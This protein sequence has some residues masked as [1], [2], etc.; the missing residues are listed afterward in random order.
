MS[1]KE[2]QTMKIRY[3]AATALLVFSSLQPISSPKPVVAETQSPLAVLMSCRGEVTIVRNDGTKVKGTFGLSL[4]AGDA[5]NTGDDAQADILFENGNYIS[6][7]AGSSMTV[8]PPKVV[9]GMGEPAKPLGD[10]GFEVTQN[11]IK[12]KSAEGTSSIAGLRGDSR[13]EELRVISPRQTRVADEH[14]VFVWE[15]SDTAEELQLIVYGETGVHW[16]GKVKGNSEMK[17]PEDAPQLASGTYYSWKLETTDPLRVPPLTST[18]AFF[19]VLDSDER[20]TLEIT[21]D[22][23]DKD[24]SLGDVSRHVMRASVFFNHGLLSDAVVETEKAVDLAP[25]DASL[26]SILA[27]LYG[28]VGRNSEAAKIYDEILKNK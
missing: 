4:E 22:R 23:I 18:A 16:Q 19:E 15:T 14:P 2:T 24:G 9:R 5:V 8:R 27:R 20:S 25:D 11:F 26:Q 28:E 7:G 6:I 13:G 12:L 17:Y 3:L 10:D 21:L 1:S